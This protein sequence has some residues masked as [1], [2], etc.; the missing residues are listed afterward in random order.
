MNPIEHVWD[1]LG[2][3]VAGR[4]PPP[5]NSPRTGKSSSGRVGQ[6]TP[7][8]MQRNVEND[9]HDLE[10]QLNDDENNISSSVSFTEIP[11][12]NF[13]ALFDLIYKNLYYFTRQS[14]LESV[15]EL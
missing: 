11:N 7:T 3:R 10:P 5:T 6:N 1:A 12:E 15:P 8:T 2:R 14:L 4:Q 9:P 13:E